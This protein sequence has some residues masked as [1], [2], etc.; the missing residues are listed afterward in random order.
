M[1]YE[2]APA[3]VA[4]VNRN[5]LGESEHFGHLTVCDATGTVVLSLGD[6][7][8][9]TFMRSSAKPFQAISLLETG[10]RDRYGWADDELAVLCSS[11]S[12]ESDHRRLVR[13]ILA[14]AGLSTGSLQCGPHLPLAGFEAERLARFRHPPRPIDSNCS[15]KHSGMIAGC[16]ANGWP[17]ESY[18]EPNHP[19]QDLNRRTVARFAGIEPTTIGIG[20][21]GCGVPTFRMSMTAFATAFARLA[22][23]DWLSEP[24]ATNARSVAQA[25][26]AFPRLISGTG[27]FDLTLSTFAGSRLVVK[28]GAEGVIGIG[29]PGTGLGLALKVDDGSNRAFAAILGRVLSRFLP[30]LPWDDY[31]AKAN[32]P[33]VN[34]RGK[35]VGA[36]DVAL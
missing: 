14:K 13:K 4:T 10:C 16:V 27:R 3:L 33:I 36:I 7:S 31:L 15:G 24:D 2:M 23:S 17:I 18:L 22:N 35:Q 26:T 19:L 32:R 29:I 6:P 12:A 21:D 1:T 8:F 25:M 9:E 11:H 28:S 20:T 34:T 5:A 30:D